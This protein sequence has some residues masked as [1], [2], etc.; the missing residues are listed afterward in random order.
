MV[1][2]GARRAN[3][4]TRAIR[5][6]NRAAGPSGLPASIQEQA[7]RGFEPPVFQRGFLAAAQQGH[8]L[9]STDDKDEE[10]LGPK[11]RIAKFD[12]AAIGID[13]RTRIISLRG[14]W[15]LRSTKSFARPGNLGASAVKKRWKAR[16]SGRSAKSKSRLPNA[17]R[18]ASTSCGIGSRTRRIPMANSAALSG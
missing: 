8:A 5:A 7:N 15:R 1:I 4:A 10:L 3:G 16:T 18:P 13:P 6:G 17:Q 9:G 2:C 12:Y 11:F 14:R